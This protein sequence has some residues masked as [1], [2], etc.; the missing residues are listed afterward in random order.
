LAE[1]YQP[2]KPMAGE[3]I[4]VSILFKFLGD[5]LPVYLLSPNPAQKSMGA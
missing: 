3:I 4:Q 2:E 5:F 1:L